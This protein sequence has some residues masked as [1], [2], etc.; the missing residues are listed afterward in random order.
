V[1]NLVSSIKSTSTPPNTRYIFIDDGSTD[2]RICELL[3]V[4]EMSSECKIKIYKND[5][6]LGYTATVN[7][8]I[9]LAGSDDLILLNSDTIVT[10]S[11]IHGL[12]SSAYLST[13]VGTVTA[14]S[15]NAGVFSFPFA[16]KKNHKIN[17]L[18]NHLHAEIVIS[19]T[20]KI[21]DISLPTGNG[22]C[23]YIKREL[24]DKIGVFDVHNFPRGY[25][26]ENDFCM[27]AKLAGFCN[28]ISTST[29]VFHAKSAS[30]GTQ[31]DFLVKS[32]IDAI[33]RLYPDYAKQ[34]SDSFSGV[35]IN[36]LRDS[37]AKLYDG[38]PLSQ[39]GMN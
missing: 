32:G 25:G 12:K 23:L 22:F 3:S 7:R 37:V 27:R 17:N 21:D 28:I 6:N 4:F 14:M 11:W 10:P 38:R 19:E 31:R 8:G 20:S 33:N 24:I 18:S 34:I 30:F 29:F 9:F 36:L 2:P 5:S 35:E 1:Q 13:N 39:I 16:G 26:E 15:D